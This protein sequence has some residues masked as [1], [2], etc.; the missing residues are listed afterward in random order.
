MATA[1]SFAGRLEQ[2]G[3]LSLAGWL[4]VSFAPGL[5]GT[6]FQPGA[7]YTQLAKPPLTPPGTVIGTV[8][9]MLYALMGVAVWLVWRQRGFSGAATALT[10]FIVQL[11]ANAVWSWLFFG[12]QLPLAALLELVIL[13]LLVLGTLVLFWRIRPL[14]GILLLPYLAWTSFAAYLNLGVWWLNR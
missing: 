11:A 12:L 5:S 10:F 2:R 4:L 1:D 8:W 9:L 13:W 6:L 14:A 3:W 7:W